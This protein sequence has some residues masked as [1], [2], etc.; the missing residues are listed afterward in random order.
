[1]LGANGATNVFYT[2]STYF[3]DGDATTDS[4]LTATEHILPDKPRMQERPVLS[5]SLAGHYREWLWNIR[6]AAAA[7]GN[8]YQFRI[9]N[10]GAA[11]Y[12]YSATPQVQVSASS[13]I[14]RRNSSFRTGCRG[15][16]Q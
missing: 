11:F 14:F 15:V 1:M 8:T 5:P 16:I 2:D 9:T 7:A 10:N 4:L 3:T 6:F 12:P 13:V